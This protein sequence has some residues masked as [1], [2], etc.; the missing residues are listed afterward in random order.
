MFFK[1]S[2]KRTSVE[3]PKSIRTLHVVP[4]NFRYD[5][6]IIIRAGYMLHFRFEEQDNHIVFCSWA[7]PYYGGPRNLRGVYFL[8]AAGLTFGD[9]AVANHIQGSLLHYRG[10]LPPFVRY[11]F[12]PTAKAWVAS[13]F[14]DKI[15]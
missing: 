4:V 14:D 2:R 8:G 1:A 11:P 12:V 5:R 10:I 7:F 3:L 13:L 6:R 15:L 9:K